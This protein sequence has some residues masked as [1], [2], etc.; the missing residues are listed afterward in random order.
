MLSVSL[1][2]RTALQECVGERA[3]GQATEVANEE[4][5][6]NEVARKQ[7]VKS[8]NLHDIEATREANR[9]SMERGVYCSSHF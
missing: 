2:E 6:I 7:S 1:E 3:D 8:R 5:N 4:R 9:S